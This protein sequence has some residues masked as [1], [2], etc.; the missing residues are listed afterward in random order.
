M[1]SSKNLD[2]D[3]I[4]IKEYIEQE[5]MFRVLEEIWCQSLDKLL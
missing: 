4:K 5:Y 1:L 3:G 2:I